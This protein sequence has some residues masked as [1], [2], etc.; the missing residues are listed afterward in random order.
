MLCLTVLCLSSGPR[1]LALHSVVLAFH[2][3]HL[4]LEALN[5]LGFSDA[6][7]EEVGF[8]LLRK[9][10]NTHILFVE[11]LN[12]ILEFYILILFY[13]LHDAR[14]QMS[15]LLNYIRFLIFLPLLLLLFVLYCFGMNQ[16]LLIRLL[17]DLKQLHYF[18]FVVTISYEF[19]GLLVEDVIFERC[20]MQFGLDFL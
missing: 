11:C 13:G 15:L 1:P 16:F 19:L 9:P 20:R 10:V 2:V 3:S 8:D 7:V 5:D 6:V 17:H 18:L 4:G 14:A 12:E